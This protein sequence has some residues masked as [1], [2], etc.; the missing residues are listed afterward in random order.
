MSRILRNERIPGVSTLL[1]QERRRDPGVK[2][3]HQ[4]LTCFSSSPVFSK[5]G[6]FI[7]EGQE[8]NSFFPARSG[9]NWFLFEIFTGWEHQG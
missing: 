7:S 8:Q 6:K 2:E 1:L 5:F 4:S 3:N 9:V